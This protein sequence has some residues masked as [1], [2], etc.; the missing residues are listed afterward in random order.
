MQVDEQSYS[1]SYMMNQ[2]VYGHYRHMSEGLF[3][4]ADFT[5]RQLHHCKIHPSMDETNKQS[6]LYP[7]SCLYNLHAAPHVG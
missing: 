1:L 7:W 3:I 4:G 2:R 5:Q 6:K